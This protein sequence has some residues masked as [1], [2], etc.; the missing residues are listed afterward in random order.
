VTAADSRWVSGDYDTLY[1]VRLTNSN[2]SITA[3]LDLDS[4]GLNGMPTNCPGA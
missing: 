2:G 3:T 1:I 4:E